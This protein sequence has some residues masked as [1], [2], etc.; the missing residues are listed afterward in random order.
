MAAAGTRVGQD[1]VDGENCF[2]VTYLPAT[3][4]L[5]VVSYFSG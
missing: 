2:A 3:G 5:A 1:F 4:W